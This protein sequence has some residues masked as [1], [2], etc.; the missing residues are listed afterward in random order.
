MK[1]DVFISEAVCCWLGPVTFGW[2]QA[3]GVHRLC[4]E[5]RYRHAPLSNVYTN[6]YS[7]QK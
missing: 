4:A 2:S 1:Y 7:E 6:V 3:D 5:V